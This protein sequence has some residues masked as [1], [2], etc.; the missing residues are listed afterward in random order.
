MVQEL[1][2]KQILSAGFIKKGS[3]ELGKPVPLCVV[4][5]VTK[6]ISGGD[7]ELRTCWDWVYSEKIWK[8]KP[9]FFRPEGPIWSPAFTFPIN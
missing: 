9:I 5:I 6:Y 2:K 1:G 3:D 4:F 8:Q 7:P